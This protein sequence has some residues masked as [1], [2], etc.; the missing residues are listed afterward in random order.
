MEL[1]WRYLRVQERFRFFVVAVY[2]VILIVIGLFWPSS[3]GFF[4][5]YWNILFASGVLVTD[6]FVIGSIG[7]SLVNAGIV[8]FIGLMLISFTKTTLSGPTIAAVFT[9]AGFALFGKT[10]IN[11]WPIIVGVAISAYIRKDQFRTYIVVAL[12]GTALGPVVSQ[13]AFGLGLGYGLAIIVGVLVGMLLPA[14]ASHVLHNHQGFSLYNVGFTCGIVGM[15]VTAVLKFRGLL[16][17]LT[18][19]W[20]Q[21]AQLQLAVIFAAYFFSMVVLGWSGREKAKELWKLPGTLVTDF[22]SE[23]SFHSALYN[24]GLVGLM[25]MLYIGLVRGDFNGP[26]IGGVFTI[27]GFGAFGKHIRNIWPIMLGVFLASHI[28][29]WQPNDPGP[30][31]AALFATTLAPIA[32]GFGPAIGILAG[33]LH[34]AV[35]MHVGAFHAGMNLYNNGFAGGLVGTLFIGLSRWFNNGKR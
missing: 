15:Y 5:A 3:V 23:Q 17:G 2:L 13:I 32:G 34:L 11:I 10:P 9:M 27:V 22:V 12:F 16:P 28:S 20:G 35:V 26:T 19:Q 24:M 18:L 6:Y 25:G 4:E 8:G 30:L 7:A 1:I 31:L 21:E 29:I 33:V 14:L